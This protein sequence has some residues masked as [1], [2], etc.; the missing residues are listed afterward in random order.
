MKNN[1]LQT[2]NKPLVSIILTTYNWPKALSRVLLAF[3][4][5]TE[6]QFEI[7]I[8]DDGSTE[9]T[10]HMI[11]DLSTH[12]NYSIQHIFQEDQGFRAA[13]IRNK[14]IAA[15]RSDYLIF[16]DHDCV[17]RKS[18]IAKHLHLREPGYFVSG[19][20]VLLNK[21][22]TEKVLQENICLHNKSWWWYFAHR[23]KKD[24]NRSFS[25]IP[26]PLGKLRKLSKKSWRGT[27]NLLAVWK[28][29]LIAVN[30]YNENYQGWGYEDTDLVVR[31]LKNNIL[32]K[33]GRFATEII[34]LYH[35][36]VS[37][38]LTEQNW[39]RLQVTLSSPLNCDFDGLNQYLSR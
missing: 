18:F 1:R 7:V 27:K 28:S 25:L 16:L 34:H 15:A 9:E 30:G 14:A 20:R 31:L 22:F 29:D 38:N 12:L 2:K 33:S 26:L 32:R 3:N 37:R 39:Q 19:N 10:S 36:F 4:D 6:K 11:R 5:Q 21:A 35:P 8:A 17:P 13:K 23:I 24:F